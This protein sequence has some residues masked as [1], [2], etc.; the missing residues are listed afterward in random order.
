MVANTRRYPA[1]A[2]GANSPLAR[3]Q[4]PRAAETAPNCLFFQ[5]YTIFSISLKGE[6]MLPC[7]VLKRDKSRP[8]YLFAVI[9][10]P[11]FR[12]AGK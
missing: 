1:V 5:I 9:Y 8:R 4:R 6:I 3:Q 2:G 7:P 11:P 12:R 10:F